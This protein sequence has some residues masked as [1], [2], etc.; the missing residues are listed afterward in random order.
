VP[1]I[2]RPLL[3]TLLVACAACDEITPASSPAVPVLVASP[4]PTVFAGTASPP[5][6]APAGPEVPATGATAEGAS[7]ASGP[8]GV[9]GLAPY[10]EAWI[11]EAEV[12]NAELSCREM[13]YRNGCSSRRRGKVTVELTLAPDGSVL[14]VE[15]IATTIVNQ[16]EVVWHCLKEK[17]PRW[18]LHAPVGVAPRLQVTVALADKC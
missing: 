1:D 16:P 12:T 10:P 9:A 14:R 7:T 8:T 5:S 11:H 4:P 13:V 17:L 2:R 15:Q 3:A 6:E 18:K